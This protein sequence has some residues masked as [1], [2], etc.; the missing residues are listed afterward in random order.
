MPYLHRD[1]VWVRIMV[2]DRVSVR[3]RARIRIQAWNGV[4]HWS[5]GSL[6]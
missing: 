6:V 4:G 1:R 5:E 2:G 3:V